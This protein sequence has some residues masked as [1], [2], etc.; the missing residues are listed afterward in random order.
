M[1]TNSLENNTFSRR[2]QQILNLKLLNE[3]LLK[4]DQD[5]RHYTFHNAL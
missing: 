3:L 2:I 5:E 1:L 4:V